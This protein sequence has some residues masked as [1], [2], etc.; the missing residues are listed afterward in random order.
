LDYF[1]ARYYSSAQGRFTSPDEFTGGPHDLFYF[2]EDAAVNPTFYA[3]LFEPQSF[4]KY[5]Y[6]YN[7]P[8][9]FVDLDGHQPGA[10]AEAL[11]A[12]WATG[13]SLEVVPGGQVV[14]TVILAGAAVGTVGYI[15]YT[16]WDSIKSGF[17]S[18]LNYASEHGGKSAAQQDAED[19]EIVR[20]GQKTQQTQQQGQQSEQQAQEA[21]VQPPQQANVPKP[22]K[23]QGS[24]PPNQR[25]P[26]RTW[27]RAENQKKLDQQNGKCAQCGDPKTVNETQGHHKQR[28]ADGGKTSD[29]NHAVVCTNCHKKL[30]Q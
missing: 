6:C 20:N 21:P 8:L 29:K 9:R 19:G 13:A 15:A 14:G 30:H 28:H 27:T 22:P 25:D 23:G 2:A 16:N 4:N 24:T 3:E 5:Q 10:T 11:K 1:L 7:N 26:K 18:F 17:K 12:A